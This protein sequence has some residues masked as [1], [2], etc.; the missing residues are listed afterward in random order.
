MDR[1]FHH[2]AFIDAQHRAF[3]RQGGV[4]AGEDFVATLEAAAKEG[5]VARIATQRFG[6]RQQRH[7]L[8]QS[9]GVRQ[10]AGQH[11]VDEDQA[12]RGDVRQQRGFDDRY[13]GVGA[14][15]APLQRTQR[16]VLPRFGARAGQAVAQRVGQCGAARGVACETCGE[17]VEQGAHQAVASGAMRSLTQA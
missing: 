9:A 7:A 2:Y 5:R 10:F 16:G 8:R 4:E 13:R 1:C 15:R 17:G 11:A 6:Q 14:K 3:A 12:R